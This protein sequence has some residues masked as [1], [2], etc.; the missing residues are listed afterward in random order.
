MAK[1]RVY[2]LAKEL[3]V[4]SKTLLNE[5]KRRGDFVRSASSTIEPGIV[6]Q[7]R[8]AAAAGDWRGPAPIPSS[9][10]PS[11]PTSTRSPESS[12]PAPFT[13]G[14]ACAPLSALTI[15]D[16]QEHPAWPI[17]PGSMIRVLECS[18]GQA[19]HAADQLRSVRRILPPPIA[20]EPVATPALERQQAD[21]S[22][23][24]R[25][26][27]REARDSRRTRRQRSRQDTP[28]GDT[29]AERDEGG[30]QLRRNRDPFQKN[31]RLT[32]RT[33]ARRLGIT[34]PEVRRLLLRARFEVIRR[35]DVPDTTVVPY[36][37]ADVAEHL[38]AQV[39]RAQQ[40]EQNRIRKIARRSK[41]Q[42]KSR[43]RASVT[44]SG[45]SSHHL[46]P[47]AVEAKELARELG[48][49]LRQLHDCAVMD[50]HHFVEGGSLPEEAAA[51]Y[52]QRG[53]DWVIQH[54]SPTASPTTSPGLAHAG[55]RPSQPMPAATSEAASRS[56][57]PLVVSAGSSLSRDEVVDLRARLRLSPP[58][59]HGEAVRT[60]QGAVMFWATR[61]A[62]DAFGEVA[63]P[64][65][66]P[67]EMFLPPAL[68]LLTDPVDEA[69]QRDLGGAVRGVSWTLVEHTTL[70]Q[71]YLWQDVNGGSTLLP[72][73]SCVFDLAAAWPTGLARDEQVAVDL[74]SRWW[75]LAH[76]TPADPVPEP[77]PQRPD[78]RREDGSS[79]VSGTATHPEVSFLTW[80]VRTPSRRTRPSP[81]HHEDAARRPARLH[82]VAAHWR[83]YG[84]GPGGSIPEK[85]FVSSHPRGGSVP[86]EK[87]AKNHLTV[88]VLRP[89]TR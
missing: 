25:T 62:Q 82:Q 52:R 12:T 56:R 50:G 53:R 86:G 17:P 37:P 26:K 9:T 7:L 65:G 81:D 11:S 34:S 46:R 39:R 73:A 88:Y 59:G 4:P 44:P 85:R 58:P 69:G 89:I 68:L 79:S 16:G 15:C 63:V 21:A 57:D 6:R 54:G 78:T 48:V 72:T 49:T 55:P 2:E 75:A 5:L 77:E 83:T 41:A 70:V 30:R 36:I 33:L 51:R 71:G 47:G 18:C 87:P 20:G 66:T 38:V 67:M 19:V 43:P 84:T 42:S 28:P 1:V 64:S 31:L 45:G 29:A 8:A 32:E 74:I 60:T 27:T 10:V 3:G 61:E 23:R 13:T 14:P 24:R 40:R 22:V 80:H 76:E 35:G